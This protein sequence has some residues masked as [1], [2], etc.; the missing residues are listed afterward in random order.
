MD[1]GQ[2]E[3]FDFALPTEPKRFK[4]FTDGD[5][6]Q[7]IPD[8]PLNLMPMVAKFRGI[9]VGDDPEA[10]LETIFS[11]TDTVLMGDSPQRLRQL[12]QDKKVGTT[13]LIRLLT[14]IVEGYGL[15]PLAASEDSSNTSSDAGTSS[16]AGAEAEESTPS[17]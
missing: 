17:L 16:T 6:F 15:R 2:V 13:G 5:E 14:W 1:N 9:N 4:L 3:V 10:A 8:L 11:V 12:V 7:A